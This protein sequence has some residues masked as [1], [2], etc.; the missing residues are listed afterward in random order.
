M[1]IKVIEA[2][3]ARTKHQQAVLDLLDMYARDPMGNGKPLSPEVRRNLIPGL[4]QHPTTLVFLAY[5]ASEPVGLAICFCGFSTFAAKPLINIHDLAVSPSYRGNGIGRKLLNA[6]AA[7]GRAIGCCKLTL[8]V[9][10]N[11]RPARQLYEGVGFRQ[12]TYQAEAGGALFMS[13]PLEES[14]I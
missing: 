8:E 2:D 14:T 11:N 7:K 1:E 13:L 10:E 9:L 6:I 4:Q 5:L 3:L 12:A